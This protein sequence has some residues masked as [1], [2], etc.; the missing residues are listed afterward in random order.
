M[1]AVCLPSPNSVFPVQ[2][3]TE[4]RVTES[5]MEK[6][7][8][9]HLIHSFSE[10]NSIPV[11]VLRRVFANSGRRR[12]TSIKYIEVIRTGTC[13]TAGFELLREPEVTWILHD[14]SVSIPVIGEGDDCLRK[15]GPEALQ[16]CLEHGVVGV[17][18]VVHSL[19]ASYVV[20]VVFGKQSQGQWQTARQWKTLDDNIFCTH[21]Q[22]WL[23]STP[24]KHQC[25]TFE[26]ITNKILYSIK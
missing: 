16:L 11:D 10:V 21:L 15:L 6:H 18:M 22:Q 25:K 14:S 3:I 9:K 24:L 4:W 20:P 19:H 17:A 5:S 8:W 13:S 7:A 1:E 23:W 26:K 2:K 12:A